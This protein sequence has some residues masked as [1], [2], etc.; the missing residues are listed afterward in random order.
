L[1]PWIIEIVRKRQIF[2]KG[3][4]LTPH[5]ISG[6]LRCQKIH[7]KWSP[8]SPRVAKGSNVRMSEEREDGHHFFYIRFFKMKHLENRKSKLR[9][10]FI[11]EILVSR[12]SKLDL[13]LIGFE[14]H[15][16]VLSILV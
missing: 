1:F 13:M 10:V 4:Y 2:A 12:S 5:V 16:F 15:F 6:A 11:F 7:G 3:K 14:I 8:C 9:T